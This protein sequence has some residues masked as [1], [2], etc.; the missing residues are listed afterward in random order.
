MTH[1]SKQVLYIDDIKTDNMQHLEEDAEMK[2]E[3]DGEKKSQT[4][5]NGNVSSGDFDILGLFLVFFFTENSL[6]APTHCIM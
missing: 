5:E 4:E 3:Q 2:C 1:W 6:T